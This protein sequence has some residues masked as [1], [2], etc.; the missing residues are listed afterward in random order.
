MEIELARCEI[1]GGA[2]KRVLAFWVGCGF[3]GGGVGGLAGVPAG[4]I[5]NNS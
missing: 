2:T 3:L 5:W 4:F 1:R